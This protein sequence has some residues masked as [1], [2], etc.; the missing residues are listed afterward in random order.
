MG[1]LTAY[2]FWV[3]VAMFGEEFGG[4]LHRM[5]TRIAGVELEAARPMT[6]ELLGA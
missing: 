3:G 2:L 5:E 4:K 1:H 6:Q